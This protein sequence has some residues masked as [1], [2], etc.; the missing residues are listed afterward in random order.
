MGGGRW[1]VIEH[2][3]KKYNV[4]IVEIK[5]LLTERQRQRERKRGIKMNSENPPGVFKLFMFLFFFCNYDRD[6]LFFQWAIL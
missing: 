2:S 1:G 4:R 5:F 6:V 3:S